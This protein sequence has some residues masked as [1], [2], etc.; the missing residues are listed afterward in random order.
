MH[1]QGYHSFNPIWDAILFEISSRQ[2]RG[3]RKIVEYFR[4][5]SM[6]RNAVKFVVVIEKDDGSKDFLGDLDD[7]TQNADGS[8]TLET[9]AQ[10]LS[11]D[12]K[13]DTIQQGCEDIMAS[14][15]SIGQVH[16]RS[17]LE[18]CIWYRVIHRSD[19]Y[20]SFITM[21]TCHLSCIDSF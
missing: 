18:Y 16:Q 4:S 6:T 11:Q 1:I 2:G 5:V 8:Y 12:Q 20:G 10:V 19:T 21:M 15:N 9:D 17:I 14:F 13:I 7:V 3:F